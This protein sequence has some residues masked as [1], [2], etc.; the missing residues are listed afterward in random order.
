MFGEGMFLV[1]GAGVLIMALATAVA[2][3]MDS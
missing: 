3:T 2:F 1:L